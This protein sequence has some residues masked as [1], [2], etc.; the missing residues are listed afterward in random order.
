M[1]S[2]QRFMRA[3]T[4]AATEATKAKITAA[5][6]AENPVKLQKQYKKHQEQVGP[7]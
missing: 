1:V 5:K 4:Q 3:I 7:Y 2:K 6:E